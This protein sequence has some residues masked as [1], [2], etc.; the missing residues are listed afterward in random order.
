MATEE[1][2]FLWATTHGRPPEQLHLQPATVH[3]R[4]GRHPQLFAQ[5]GAQFLQAV[6]S[7]AES[8]HRGD[9]RLRPRCDGD[10]DTEPVRHAETRQERCSSAAH[11]TRCQPTAHPF[12][13][14]PAAIE[15]HQQYLRPS[16]GPADRPPDWHPA[17]GSGQGQTEGPDEGQT[18]CPQRQ[19]NHQRFCLLLH[20]RRH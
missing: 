15:P 10:E 12:L 1:H 3:R 4:Y 9:G 13:S 16:A 8:S 6:V 5:G 18:R 14:R 11:N 7:A 17:Q 19:G 2:R 20:L